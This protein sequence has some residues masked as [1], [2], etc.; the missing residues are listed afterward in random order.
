MS[1]EITRRKFLKDVLSHT[2][3]FSFGS[4][5]LGLAEGFRFKGTIQC[6]NCGSINIVIKPY[7]SFLIFTDDTLYC[8]D[9]GI[10]LNTFNFDIIDGDSCQGCKKK[11]TNKNRFESSVCC[12]IPFP[13]H[14]YLKKTKKPCF[15]IKDIKF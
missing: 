3:V 13:N 2:T 5:G 6:K 9:C 8:Y 10:N 1:N 11:I 12:Q 7:L 15:S 14:K 4:A